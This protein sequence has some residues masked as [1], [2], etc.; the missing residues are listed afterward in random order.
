[1]SDNLPPDARLAIESYTPFVDPNNF[2]VQSFVRIID[3]PPDWYI[4]NGFEYLV[5]GEA[6]FGR[7]Y[8]MPDRYNNEIEMYNLFFD[9]FELIRTFSDGGYEV[10]IYSISR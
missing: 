8:A 5:F 1:M 10:R 7:F 6:M 4:D 3:Q 2:M 9:R